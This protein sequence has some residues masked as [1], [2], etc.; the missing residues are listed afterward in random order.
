MKSCAYSHSKFNCSKQTCNCT[1]LRAIK[2]VNVTEMGVVSS[3]Y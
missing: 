2:T 1:N 3:I